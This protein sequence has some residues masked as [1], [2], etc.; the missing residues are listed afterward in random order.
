MSD[1]EVKSRKEQSVINQIKLAKLRYQRE[2][3]AKCLDHVYLILQKLPPSITVAAKMPS[4]DSA[5]KPKP[6]SLPAPKAQPQPIPRMPIPRAAPTGRQADVGKSA[7]VSSG[8]G[9]KGKSA[10]RTNRNNS[11]TA[12]LPTKSNQPKANE[13]STREETKE[14]PAYLLMMKKAE[15]IELNLKTLDAEIAELTKEEENN[16]ILQ[17]YLLL[18]NM[19]QMQ[20]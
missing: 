17:Q 7:P 18:Q 13:R 19:Q 10:P 20:S 6:E 5:K 12:A 3:C 11:Q 1:A 14:N 16:N 2:A 8:G 4:G 15:R 9:G